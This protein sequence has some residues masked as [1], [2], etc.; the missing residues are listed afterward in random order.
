MQV[1]PP[2]IVVGLLLQGQ[3]TQGQ[4]AVE[5]HL[6]ILPEHPRPLL[7]CLE[8]TRRPAMADHVDR[9]SPVGKQVMLMKAWY[10]ETCARMLAIIDG[11]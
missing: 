11:R 3:G 2:R 5:P 7:L 10:S 1:P 8:Q 9:N 4:L 6:Q